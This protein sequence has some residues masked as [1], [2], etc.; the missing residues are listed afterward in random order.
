MCLP[1]DQKKSFLAQLAA[2]SNMSKNEIT[3]VVENAVAGK[4][5]H[6]LSSHSIQDLTLFH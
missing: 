1:Q 2:I 3:E 4:S 5:K 6:L